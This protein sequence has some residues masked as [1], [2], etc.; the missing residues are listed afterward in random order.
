MMTSLRIF[1]ETARDVG[2]YIN[3]VLLCVVCSVKDV[4]MSRY[5]NR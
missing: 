1:K 2:R 5:Y 4:G 3:R